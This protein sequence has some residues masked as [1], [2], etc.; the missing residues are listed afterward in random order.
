MLLKLIF[1]GNDKILSELFK[2]SWK[3]AKEKK[4]ADEPGTSNTIKE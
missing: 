4:I 2:S 3:N 1:L